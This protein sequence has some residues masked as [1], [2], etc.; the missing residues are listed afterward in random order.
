[1]YSLVRRTPARRAHHSRARRAALASG[2]ERKEREA[3]R[4]MTNPHPGAGRQ[5]GNRG[6]AAGTRRARR[7]A[8]EVAHHVVGCVA[9]ESPRERY[10]GDIGL[11]LGCPSERRPQRREQLP[12]ARRQRVTLRADRQARAVEPHLQRVAET[13]ERVTRQP[14]AALDAL[15][16]DRKSTRLNSSH[17]QISYAVFCLK[18][19]NTYLVID[20]SAR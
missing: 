1:M 18:T 11:R 20:P 5:V 6:R 4:K 8:L 9:D 3:G 15:E 14:L 16:Q 19:K 13:D 12:A 7:Q 10:A 2:P 17:S